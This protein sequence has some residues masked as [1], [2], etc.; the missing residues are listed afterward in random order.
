MAKLETPQNVSLDGTVLSWDSVPG[1]TAYN[2][3]ADNALY[4]TVVNNVMP[5]IF[6]Q[7]TT[8]AAS[9]MSNTTNYPVH[10]GTLYFTKDNFIV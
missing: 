6:K 2:I 10:P 7:S 4:T 3:Y 1:A 5:V 8:A 9:A